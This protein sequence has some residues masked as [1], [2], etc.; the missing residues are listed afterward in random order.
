MEDKYIR[1][2][3][4]GKC[5]VKNVADAEEWDKTKRAPQH[6]AWLHDKTKSFKK[7]TVV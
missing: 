3:K 2:S 7:G 5:D 1:Y 6:A 4:L